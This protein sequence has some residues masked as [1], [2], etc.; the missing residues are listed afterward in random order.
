MIRGPEAPQSKGPTAA[1]RRPMA[2]Q[3]LPVALRRRWCYQADLQEITKI[4][5]SLRARQFQRPL[6]KFANLQ[7]AEI[8]AATLF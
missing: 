5:A 6:S 7:T 3:W 4:I 2:S 8:Q 1:P